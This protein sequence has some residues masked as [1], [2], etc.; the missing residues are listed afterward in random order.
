MFHS[1]LLNESER[2]HFFAAYDYAARTVRAC[3]AFFLEAQEDIRKLAHA[4]GK[5]HH[6]TS[7]ML[8]VG[9]AEAIDGVT[10]LVGNGSAKN[11]GHMLRTAFES[12]LGLCYIWEDAANY[13]RRSRAYQVAHLHQR[14]KWAQRCDQDSPLGK[15]LKAELKDDPFADLFFSQSAL[16]KTQ[17]KDWEQRLQSPKYAPIEQEWQATKKAQSGKEPNWYSLWGGPKDI[18][19]L[20]LRLRKGSAYEALYRNWSETTHA[21]DALSRILNKGEGDMI[22]L[23]PIRSPRGLRTVCQHA[24]NFSVETA[25]VAIQKLADHLWPN[26]QRRYLEDLREKLK[27]PDRLA[28][29]DSASPSVHEM[30]DG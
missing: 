5:D 18:R 9:L 21:E 28:G 6:V 29:F 22:H 27:G 1:E 7:L 15:Q 24:C 8:M 3:L 10:I 17:T 12:Q 2:K 16:A 23:D 30:K 20:A 26:Y 4:D 11:C 19:R 14:L 13:E 25:R